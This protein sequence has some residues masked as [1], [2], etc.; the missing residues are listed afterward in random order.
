[1]TKELRCRN[2]PTDVWDI[3]YDKQ[4]DLKKIARSNVSIDR[5]VIRI[6]KEW[7]QLQTEKLPK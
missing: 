7:K 2:I 4:T 6:I 1:M 3:I 5:T